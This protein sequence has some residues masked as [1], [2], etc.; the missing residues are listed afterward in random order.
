MIDY[1]NQLDKKLAEYR[2]KRLYLYGAGNM[3]DVAYKILSHYGLNVV[4]YIVTKGAGE[5][6]GLSVQEIAKLKLNSDND[7]KIILTLNDAY[8]AEVKKLLH[9]K[10]I[11]DID[12]TFTESQLYF[13]AEIYRDVFR[14]HGID[15][16]GGDTLSINKLQLPNPYMFQEMSPFWLECGDLLLPAMFDDYRFICEGPYEYEAV[17]LEKDDVVIDCGANI[18][19]FSAYAASKGCHTL[20]FEPL[21]DELG[22]M[23][24]R[25]I[26][27]NKNIEHIP[28]AVSDS[29]GKLNFNVSNNIQGSSF[30]SDVN[31]D[32]KNKVI[33]KIV[34][35]DVTTL[36]DFA[37]SRHLSH[38]D[39]IK[40]DIEGAE[41]HMLKGATRVLREFHPK[42]AICTYHYSDDPQVLESIIKAANPRYH[43]IHRWK[44]LFAYI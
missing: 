6:N 22:E 27:L 17:K 20:A 29:N 7:I 33:E 13:F 30:L 38:L 31:S 3:G 5:L 16:D 8:H 36:D 15:V 25:C 35:V 41:R 39:F 43:V 2:G 40:A 21:A 26:A 42:L 34:S 32:S 11:Y 28:Y 18:G 19:L 1:K 24:N 37:E 10:E 23:L 4:G 9:D 14:A 44:K 12:D